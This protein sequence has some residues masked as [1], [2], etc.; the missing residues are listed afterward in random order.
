MK[1]YCLKC[2]TRMQ[3]SSSVYISCIEC[4]ASYRIKDNCISIIHPLQ[5][6]ADNQVQ[7]PAEFSKV[8]D[9]HFWDLV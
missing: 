3:N 1:L 9:K 4:G 6:L 7:L 5:D 2:G 8:V